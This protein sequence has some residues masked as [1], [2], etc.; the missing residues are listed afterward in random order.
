MKQGRRRMALLVV[1]ALL[2]TLAVP[3]S[4]MAAPEVP[5]D[6]QVEGQTVAVGKEATFEVKSAGGSSL[7]GLTFQWEVSTDDG[8]TWNPVGDGLGDNTLTYTT[9]AATQE[10][11]GWQYRCYVASEPQEGKSTAGVLT[12]TGAPVD[13]N[14]TPIVTAEADPAGQLVDG[15]SVTLTAKITMNP[16]SGR[17]IQWYVIKQDAEGK[18]LAAEA[19]SGATAEELVL[20]PVTA[21]MNGWKYY[22]VVTNTTYPDTTEG[23]SNEI[24]LNVREK[25]GAITIASQPK[26]ASVLEGETV[27][28]AVDAVAENGDELSYQW[29]MSLTGAGGSYRDVTGAQNSPELTLESVTTARAGWYL[30]VITNTVDG[31]SVTSKA[32]QLTVTARTATPAVTSD[33]EATTTVFAGEPVTLSVEAVIT[34]GD[35]AAYQWQVKMPGKNWEDIVGANSASYTVAAEDVQDGSS[36]RC[37]VTNADDADEA[38]V[39]SDETE[40]SLQHR[41]FIPEILAQPEDVTV[42][43]GAKDVKIGI[44]IAPVAE[45]SEAVYTVQAQMWDYNTCK[46]VSKWSPIT[47]SATENEDGI[48]EIYLAR[49]A[50]ISAITP[51]GM[52]TYRFVVTTTNSGADIAANGESVIS[53]AANVTVIQ[54]NYPQITAQPQDAAAQV[55]GSA[56]FSVEATVTPDA[57]L[58]YQWYGPAGAIEG[59][60]AASYTVEDATIEMDGG[61]YYCVVTNEQY[62]VSTQS[63]RA[64][65]TVTDEA[66]VI[67]GDVN[68][69]GKL[70]PTDLAQLA[71]AL[72]GERELTGA[73]AEAAD[74][75]GDGKISPTDLAQ[76]AQA[77]L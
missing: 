73:S 2:V 42:E 52:Q 24:T 43:A 41:D 34:N 46:W 44:Q 55:G 36:Y 19:V 70:S 76:L 17:A 38:A 33:F 18:D 54:K 7:E 65:L 59:A 53:D 47:V 39:Y 58:G 72:I 6:L 26:S 28:F 29:R 40:L 51:T 63:Y 62:R 4:A 77:L 71:Q 30:C 27:T 16:E 8:K 75:N 20:D 45:D 68:G 5:G 10:M 48:V 61:L 57:R 31:S 1:I 66:P 50:G 11:N 3:M 74:M 12:V 64:E 37:V 49:E 22:C 69:D 14:E 25:T 35:A 15:D 21:D 13:D 23:E 56:T 9:E 67:P 60:T 32:A